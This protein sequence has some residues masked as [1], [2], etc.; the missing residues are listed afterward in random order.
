MVEL[1][2]IIYSG[3]VTYDTLGRALQPARMASLLTKLEIP[4]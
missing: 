1:Y 3:S 4:G 2:E